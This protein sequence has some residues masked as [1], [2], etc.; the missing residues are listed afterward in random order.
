MQFVFISFKI[1]NLCLESHLEVTG[2]GLQLR[3]V[4][5]GG[6]SGQPWVSTDKKASPYSS[7]RTYTLGA[8]CPHVS[9][10][11]VLQVEQGL[12]SKEG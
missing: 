8:G 4:G 3:D 11:A 12:P 9:P 10:C 1:M 6:T 5:P 2:S 7:H